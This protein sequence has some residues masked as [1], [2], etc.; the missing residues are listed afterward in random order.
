ML[1]ILEGVADCMGLVGHRLAK[2]RCRAN[3]HHACR[4]RSA[5]RIVVHGLRVFGVGVSR[6]HDGTLY[7]TLLCIG[8]L[9]C[10]GRL[11]DSHRA[12]AACEALRYQ[13]RGRSF[14]L[15]QDQVCLLLRTLA[16]LVAEDALPALG[17]PSLRCL[18]LVVTSPH[19][20]TCC[21]SGCMARSYGHL[22]GPL[23]LHLLHLLHLRRCFLGECAHPASTRLEEGISSIH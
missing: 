3:R 1:C 16:H 8:N 6:V 22:S 14:L 7:A 23:L 4:P 12:A 20:P 18:E 17:H 11:R 10:I 9:R 2:T 13:F 5:V 15:G 21:V 19:L